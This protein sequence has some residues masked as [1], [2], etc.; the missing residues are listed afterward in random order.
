MA[1][2][3]NFGAAGYGQVIGS[4]FGMMASREMGRAAR[5]QGERQRVAAEFASYQADQQAGIALGLSQQQAAEERRQARHAASRALAVAAASGAGVSDPTMVRILADIRG[6]GAYRASVA[7]YEG[8][9]K[10]RTL[11]LDAA[12]GRVAGY[13]AEA[14][15]ASRDAGYALAG[16]GKGVGGAMSLYARYGGSGPQVTGSG[17]YKLID[18]ND[19]GGGV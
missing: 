10:A 12:A 9:A 17:D 15:G 13:D 8:E 19:Y 14:E 18:R 4:I 16:L 2:P 3:T 7:L 6:L 11:R 5:V 1:E